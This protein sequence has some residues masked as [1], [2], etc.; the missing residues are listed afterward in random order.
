[1]DWTLFVLVLAVTSV[2]EVSGRRAES[3]RISKLEEAIHKLSREVKDLKSVRCRQERTGETAS[4]EIKLAQDTLS[5]LEV[6]SRALSQFDSQMRDLQN[7]L[8]NLHLHKGHQVETI[9]LFRQE[10]TL[11]K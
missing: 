9:D 1:M 11:L 6:E 7:S 8:E 3:K 10:I 5:A 2:L 4:Q